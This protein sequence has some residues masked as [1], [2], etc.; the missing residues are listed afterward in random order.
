LGGVVHGGMLGYVDGWKTRNI[1]ELFV[2]L[3]FILLGVW[4]ATRQKRLYDGP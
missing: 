1:T 3:F 4:I 2:G